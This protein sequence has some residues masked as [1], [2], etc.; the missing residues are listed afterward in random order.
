MGS[1]VS[2]RPAI[3]EETKIVVTSRIQLRQGTTNLHPSSL[4]P[5]V[6]EIWQLPIA[7]DYSIPQFQNINPSVSRPAGRLMHFLPNWKKLTSDRLLLQIVRL[8]LQ[9]PPEVCTTSVATKIDKRKFKRTNKVAQNSNTRAPGERSIEGSEQS[10]RSVPVN[11][12]YFETRREESSSVQ[13]KITEPRC[14]AGEV[15][16]ERLG[17][18]SD[19]S[20][21]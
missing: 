5:N 18:C 9:N 16:T 4:H 15:E 17:D 19:P 2:S 7:A 12:V 6:L 14:T 1:P 20:P 21:T 10:R 8:R 3:V 11:T 13:P